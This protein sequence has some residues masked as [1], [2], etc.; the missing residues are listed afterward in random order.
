MLEHIV[1]MLW[2]VMI[3]L[4]FTVDSLDTNFFTAVQYSYLLFLALPATIFVILLTDIIYEKYIAK[5]QKSHKGIYNRFLVL[6]VCLSTSAISF[7][8]IISLFLSNSIDF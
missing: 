1:M 3:I 6:L 5:L 7:F 2:L 8:F 4:L